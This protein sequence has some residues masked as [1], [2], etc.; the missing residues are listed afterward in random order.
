MSKQQTLVAT[1][2]LLSTKLTRAKSYMLSKQNCV[3]VSLR[4]LLWTAPFAQFPECPRMGWHHCSPPRPALPPAPGTSGSRASSCS[5]QPISVLAGEQLLV[6]A[7]VYKQ[8]KGQERPKNP[9]EIPVKADRE[10]IN[11]HTRLSFLRLFL[12]WPRLG[13]ICWEGRG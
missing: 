3:Q 9:R 11:S 2:L 10:E 4:S 1:L 13:V 12:V 6:S 8:Q 5:W 7:C